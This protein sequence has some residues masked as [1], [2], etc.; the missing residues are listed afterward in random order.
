MKVVIV[1]LDAVLLIRDVIHDW[2]ID[3]F[4][5]F[6]A[7]R[8]SIRN[9]SPHKMFWVAA[10]SAAQDGSADEI[11]SRAHARMGYAHGLFSAAHE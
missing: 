8:A 6:C 2:S 10:W 9:A 3:S 4:V 11:I 7:S 1:A 5:D